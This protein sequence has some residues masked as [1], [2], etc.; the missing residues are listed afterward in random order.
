MGGSKAAS[1]I[2]WMRA[3]NSSVMGFT[4]ASLSSR[5]GI[6]FVPSVARFTGLRFLHCRDPSTEVPGYS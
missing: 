2:D 4:L 5:N 3:F 1:D 6:G